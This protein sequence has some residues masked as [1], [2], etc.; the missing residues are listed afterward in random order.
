M[1]SFEDDED[2]ALG[3]GEESQD[4]DEN[5]EDA[6]DVDVDADA[7]AD[8]EGDGDADAE[9]DMDA[10]GDNDEDNDDNDNDEDEDQDEAESP[11]SRRASRPQG[12]SPRDRPPNPTV[13]LTSPSP[14]PSAARSPHAAYSYIPS[15][16]PEALTASVYDIVPTMAA[17]Q[18]TS[19]NA[20][21]ATPD[22][23]WVFSGGQDGYIRMY[24]WVETANGKVPLTVAQKH[25]FVDSV[26][27]AGSL[28]TY[29]ENEERSFR[30][31]PAQSADEP[32]DSSPVYSLAAQREAVWLLSGLESGAINLQTCR[33][34]AG[35]LITS[36]REHT[37]AVSVLNLAQ[38][39]KS[40]LSGSWDKVIHDWDLNTGKVKRSFRGSGS[41]ISAIEPRPT[42]SLPIP[43]IDEEAQP[44][45]AT[46][47]SNNE[48]KPLP[49]G[50]STNG[51][52]TERKNSRTSANG[53]EDAPGSDDGSLFGDGDHGSL[54][55][56]DDNTNNAGGSGGF[57][58]DD[59]DEFSKALATGLQ[60]Q[61][62]ED[63]AQNPDTEMADANAG[64]PVQ[65][66]EPTATQPET[67]LAQT[68]GAAD[69]ATAPPPSTD[70]AAPSKPLSNGLPVSEDA[71]TSFPNGLSVT[72]NSTDKPTHSHSTFLSA[73]ID[74]TLRIWDR[75]VSAPVARILPPRNTPP[76]C[77]GACWS[78]D[79]NFFY[80]GRRNGTVDEYSIHKGMG[81]AQ[82]RRTFKFPAGSGPVSAI[83]A[84]PNGRHLVW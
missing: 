30:T 43:H 17:P 50:I 4:I 79:G 31:P 12:Q 34:Q 23:R 7:D 6:D 3:S 32:K 82:P 68:D 67:G 8:A 63:A 2:P 24:N 26:M 9:G 81:M 69:T 71:P 80:A 1:V 25:P 73:S 62:D 28:T 64:G 46:F 21:T 56:D 74:G 53:T 58:Q 5:M 15:V 78:P 10:E 51:S 47:S 40:F 42:S 49:N 48:A 41:Q 18:S 76:W 65:P 75:R 59:D 44:R 77:M 33:H 22:M 36:L 39:E 60:Q 54:F 55:G 57:D 16:R 19:I 61:A 38:D 13:L 27:K 14:R 84:M 83:R 11:T 45:S 70:S 52:G 29:W 72:D 66:P 20:V 35:T 37:S